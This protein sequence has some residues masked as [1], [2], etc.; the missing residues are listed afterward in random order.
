MRQQLFN[1]VLP[2]DGL[3][4]IV[5][6]M[7]NK[8]APPIVEY[9]QIGSEEVHTRIDELDASGR[10]VYFG[11]ASYRDSTKPKD[12]HNIEG[13]C[14]FYLDLDC[15]KADGYSTKK[16]AHQALTEFCTKIGLPIP[17]T[18]DS[19]FGIH[20]YWSLQET[21]DYNEWKP[22]AN[23]LKSKCL[24]HMLKAD[25]SVTA[26]GA[27]IL[28][29]P[30]TMNKKR[31]SD[32]RKVTVRGTIQ[33][34][35]S[36]NAF[37]SCVGCLEHGDVV[38]SKD[39]PVMSALLNRSNK[40]KFSRIYRKSIEMIPTT[41]KVEEEY[42]MPDGSRAI[43]LV[44]QKVERSAGCPQIAY[45]I[46][47]RETLNEPTWRAALSTANCCID[48]LEAIDAVSKDH[49]DYDLVFAVRYAEEHTKGGLSCDE[50]RA[51]SSQ[52]QLCSTCIHKGKIKNP[53]A[54]G[55]VVEEALPE[56]NIV[57][58]MHQDLG[59]EVTIE[60]PNE[61]PHPWI[62]P[63]EGGVALRGAADRLGMDDERGE[64]E[65]D[66]DEMI[67]YPRDLWVKSRL[68]DGEQEYVEMALRLPND[69]LVEFKAPLAYMLKQDKCQE[70]LNSKGCAVVGKRAALI[71]SYIAAWVNKLQN[72][73][74]AVESRPQFGW[75]DNDTRFV[76][77][78]REIDT[79]GNIHFSPVHAHIENV[80]RIYRKEGNL[81]DWQRMANLYSAAGNEVRAFGLFCSF[82]APLYKF[83]GEGSVIMHL[84]NIASGVGKSTI[85]KVGLSVWGCPLEGL[86]TN[87]D[88]VNARLHR[89]GVL[90]NL[91]AFIDEITNIRP[92]QVSPFA[93]DLS[94]G[95]AKNRMKA[96]SNEERINS[97]T[98]STIIQTS[99][100]NSL[101]DVIMSCKAAGEGEMYR[102]LEIPV[103]QDFH[104][105]KQ[106]ADEYYGHILTRNFGV[107][108]DAFL[109]YVV[110]NL[111][112]AKDIQ[113]EMR[114]KFDREADM[115]G[116]ERFY[117]ACFA[118]AFAGAAIA[119]DLGI[120]NI[121]LEPVWDWAL[122]TLSTIRSTVRGVSLDRTENLLNLLSRF[123]NEHIQYI[124]MTNSGVLGELG[125][126]APNKTPTLNPPKG[127]LVGRHDVS[128]ERLYIDSKVLN[129]WLS[130]RQNTAPQQLTT[131][132]RDIGVLVFHGR[133]DIG[134]GTMLYST[135]LAEVYG[136]DAKILKTPI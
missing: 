71:R 23:A 37:R 40:F 94:A 42:V 102:I 36:V 112:I 118:S 74:K 100:N 26:D 58:V 20:A 121:P 83:L 48:R 49:P 61:Y 50:W 84:T 97:S 103:D 132:M 55:V 108:G 4:C 44:S 19:G 98:W 105:S 32:H 88:T 114:D 64:E 31:G 115:V 101:Y 90:N 66:P 28:R 67:V 33:A 43:R 3:I 70:V 11:V 63:K 35:V 53:L 119:N 80:A 8:S 1:S 13:K 30:G 27:R 10:E 51:A 120:I 46:A 95:R 60:I 57:T 18:V 99:G 110:P 129:D 52:P 56:D 78:N 89:M 17:T 92:D 127:R 72:D 7:H 81:S 82:G 113:L 59:E 9:F 45:A 47:N 136:F 106:E 79:Q 125:E 54:L 133:Y 62:R 117:S 116:K 87:N 75:C 130:S 65:E 6:L 38:A 34:P 24:D 134:N 76:V 22:I 128:A 109:K 123:W 16:E 29:V 135:G 124:L 14:A 122:E 21:L 73:S 2:E 41:E 126:D 77:G 104:I 5:G 39:D 15:G 68:K 96:S 12:V 91:P 107:A 69:G 25:R 131:A 86:L 93:F 111:D 85:Q